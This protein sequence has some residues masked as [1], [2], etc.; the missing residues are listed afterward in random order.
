MIDALFSQTNYAAVKK[1]LDATALRHEAIA[2]NLANVEN[3]GYQ[4]LDVNPSFSAELKQAMSA[5]DGS[6]IQNL[7]PS[8]T[9]DP[10]AV[11][12]T[13]DGNTVQLEKELI[14]LNQNT[15]AHAL[16]T[17]LVTGQL[18]RLRLAITGRSN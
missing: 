10:N 18:L 15:I 3:P 2:S 7:Q 16:E 12:T 5:P 13:R 8:L 4:R 9:V 14:S 6:Q 11:A 17:Q 1:M